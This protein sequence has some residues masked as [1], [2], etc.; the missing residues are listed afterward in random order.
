MRFNSRDYPVAEMQPVWLAVLRT[1]VEQRGLDV[2]G[3]DLRSVSDIADCFV[4]ASGTSQRHV[5]GLA[6]KVKLTLEALGEKPQRMTGYE[7]GEWILIDCGD[8]IVHLFYEP[9]RQYY[10][11][12][13]L[14]SAA[15]PVQMDEELELR[16]R[17]SRT[18]M[19]F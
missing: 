1:L 9:V 17:K 12:D 14:W 6:D 2:R 15:L 5:Q 7:N 8:L 3:L 10:E 19:F 13:A 18:G 16:A 11:F 4:M